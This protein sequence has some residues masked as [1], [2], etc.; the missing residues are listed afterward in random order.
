MLSILQDPSKKT[1][2]KVEMAAVVDAG[3]QFV[4]ATYKLE[5]NEPLVLY[6]YE[7]I[8]AAVHAIQVRHF[9]NTD[10]VIRDLSV[11]QPAHFAPQLK[12]YAESCVQPGFSVDSMDSWVAHWQHSKQLDCFCH[13]KCVNFRWMQQVWTA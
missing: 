6:C 3:K 2:L 10:A 4:Q 7:Y 5:G 9:P 13:T 12:A 1:H 8:E 11:G